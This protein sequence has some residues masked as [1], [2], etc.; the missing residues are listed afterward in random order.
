MDNLTSVCKFFENSPK[1]QKY[2][3]CFLEFYKVDLNLPETKRK[4]I[5]GLAKTRWVEI[6]KAYDTYHLL[7]KGTFESIKNRNLYDG[8]CKHLQEKCNEN[9]TW[10]AETKIKAQGLFNATKLFEHILAISLVSN[11][12]ESLSYEVAETQPRHLQVYQII[13]NVNFE[14][15]GF[16]DNVDI[17]FEHWFNFGEILGEEVNAVPSV[18]RL[19]KSWSRFR[20]NV[21]NNSFYVI[22]REA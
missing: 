15:R 9:W 12:L 17:E 5:I 7:Y 22:I 3:E 4:E 6:Y 14:S 1:R 16:R 13:D 21:E 18:P 19:A 2:F 11:G 10:D 8:F 20:Q